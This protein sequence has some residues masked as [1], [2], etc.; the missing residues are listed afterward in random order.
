MHFEMQ[1]DLYQLATNKEITLPF[2]W[3][4]EM[5]QLSILSLILDL[6]KMERRLWIR[7]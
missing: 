6:Y 5:S 3:I 1:W 2:S 4:E 7:S